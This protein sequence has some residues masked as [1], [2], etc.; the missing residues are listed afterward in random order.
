MTLRSNTRRSKKMNDATER[1]E[2]PEIP[3]YDPKMIRRASRRGI[4]RVTLIV[5]VIIA[6]ISAVAINGS[7][8]ISHSHHPWRHTVTA[9]ESAALAH[10]GYDQYSWMSYH[11]TNQHMS[12]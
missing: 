8:W 9:T 10:P 1:D 12:R 4:V 3:E 7:G 2:L 5:I 11:V 6:T